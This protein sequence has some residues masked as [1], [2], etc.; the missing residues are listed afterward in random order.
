[1]KPEI[2]IPESFLPLRPDY[3]NKY[4]FG[5]RLIIAGSKGMTGAAVLAAKAAL[6][7]GAGLVTVA[8]PDTER[9]IIATALPETMTFGAYSE[10]G[11]FCAESAKEI[12]SFVKSRK[13]SAMLIG[14]GLSCTEKTTE[15]VKIIMENC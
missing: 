14:P 12:L 4:T 5:S 3:A 10:N 1:M 8:C 11:A 6:R 15:F 2:Q 13:F 7:A 9:A